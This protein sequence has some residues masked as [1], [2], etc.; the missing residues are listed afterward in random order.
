[1]DT[2]QTIY[3]LKVALWDLSYTHWKA[4]VLFS[5]RWWSLV[6]LIAIA[7]T[8]WWKLVDKQ[9]LSQILLFGSF[10]AVGRIVM[11]LIGSNIVLWSYD[12]R[13][14]PFSPSPFLHDFTITPLAL[15]L[16]NQYC[17]SWNKFLVWTA[18]VTGIITFVFFPLLIAFNFLKYYNWNHFYSFVLIIG[19]ASLSRVVLLEVL[20]LEQRYQCSVS[21]GSPGKPICRPAMKPLSE[22]EKRDQR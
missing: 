7:Y 5:I 21:H 8:V 4:N 20:Q 18:V 13:E 3:Q 15:M 14:L 10:V 16:V 22:D 6:A 19:I 2:A 12:V 1:M 9:R 11:D 17:P